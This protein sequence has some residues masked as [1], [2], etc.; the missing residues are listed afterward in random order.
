MFSHISLRAKVILILLVSNTLSSF[1]FNES[2]VTLYPAT[3]R[4]LDPFMTTWKRSRLHLLSN[5]SLLP[6]TTN[7]RWTHKFS[8]LIFPLWHQPSTLLSYFSWWLPTDPRPLLF[9]PFHPCWCCLGHTFLPHTCH[10]PHHFH[11]YKEILWRLWTY[12]PHFRHLLETRHAFPSSPTSSTNASIQP[13][14]LFHT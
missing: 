3:G 11:H 1:I 10:G 2:M 12:Q 9:N 4:L 7:H 6:S 5:S 14:T 13:K 8:F